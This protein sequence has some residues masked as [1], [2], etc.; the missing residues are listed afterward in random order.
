[1]FV[2]KSVVNACYTFEMQLFPISKNGRNILVRSQIEALLLFIR[3]SAHQLTNLLRS[4]ISLSSNH[5]SQSF[6]ALKRYYN[7]V[8]N[9]LP[10]DEFCMWAKVMRRRSR[11]A[12]ENYLCSQGFVKELMQMHYREAGYVSEQISC[13]AL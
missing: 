2:G 8:G 12:K 3:Q 5:L 4:I 13:C 11:N 7:Q 10:F 6:V 1:M 9:S